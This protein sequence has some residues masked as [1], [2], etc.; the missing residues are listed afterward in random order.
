ME[1]DWRGLD[2]AAHPVTAKVNGKGAF[3]GQGSNVLGDP[4]LALAWLANELSQHGYSL[5]AGQV[6]MTGTCMTPVSI[7]AGDQVEADF[8]PLGAVSVHFT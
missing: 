8:G 3:A 1:A 6:V 5:L 2:L 4:R 7:A